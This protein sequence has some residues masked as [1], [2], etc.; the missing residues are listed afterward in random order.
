MMEK[1]I[2]W[3]QSLALRFGLIH[4]IG[5]NMLEFRNNYNQILF[6]LDEAKTMNF[7]NYLPFLFKLWNLLMEGCNECFKDSSKEQ[8]FSKIICTGHQSLHADFEIHPNIVFL[9]ITSCQLENGC[10][11]WNEF[12]IGHDEQQLV[13]NFF[14]KHFNV[15]F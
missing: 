1:Y 8:V 7:I 3:E 14:T 12:F 11:Q 4:I 6:Y 2:N 13:M 10:Y 5:G 15:I 9:I